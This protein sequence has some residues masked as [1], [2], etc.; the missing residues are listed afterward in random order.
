MYKLRQGP[1]A[2]AYAGSPL[3]PKHFRGTG[4]TRVSACISK[5]PTFPVRM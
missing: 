3:T 5:G 1:L 4:V 2:L